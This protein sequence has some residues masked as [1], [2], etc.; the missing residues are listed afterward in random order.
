MHN[1]ELIAEWVGIELVECPLDW[2]DH[3]ACEIGD[4]ALSSGY[5][6]GIF[7][8]ARDS[9]DAEDVLIAVVN[10]GADDYCDWWQPDTNITLWHGPDGLLEEIERRRCVALFSGFLLG[11]EWPTSGY[12]SFWIGLTATP[13]QLADALVKMIE[14]EAS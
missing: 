1:N 13:A 3:S 2:A 9:E 5:T 7:V 11:Q 12:G 4:W 10:D 6:N 14:E 8:V